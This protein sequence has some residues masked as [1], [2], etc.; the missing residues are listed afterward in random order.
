MVCVEDQR[1]I[2]PEKQKLVESNSM[3]WKKKQANWQMEAPR[4]SSSTKSTWVTA[5]TKPKFISDNAWAKNQSNDT[6]G[7]NLP[8]HWGEVDASLQCF[9]METDSLK[10]DEVWVGKRWWSVGLMEE[11]GWRNGHEETPNE[12]YGRDK[13]EVWQ[14]ELFNVPTVLVK[15]VQELVVVPQIQCIA[16]Y[17]GKTRSINLQCSE[18]VEVPQTAIQRKGGQCPC[19]GAQAFS[20]HS[21][22]KEARLS[23]PG[24]R[25]KSQ[26]A[27]VVKI[28]LWELRLE[29]K[30]RSMSC[31]VY[32]LLFSF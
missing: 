3:T 22:K 32:Y 17:D 21:K 7:K 11:H 24:S 10:E 6:K 5:H 23:P 26:I 12:N 16:V 29:R 30:H 2:V 20:H 27:C 8:N 25:V 28:V 13:T 31:H 18:T 15:V 9:G 14:V 1:K 19:R 4:L